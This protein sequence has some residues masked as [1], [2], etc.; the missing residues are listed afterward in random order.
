MAILKGL[1]QMW[2]WFYRDGTIQFSKSFESRVKWGTC[3]FLT[4]NI[5]FWLNCRIQGHSFPCNGT[6]TVI[7]V[8]CLVQTI[9]LLNNWHYLPPW[10]PFMLYTAVAL[11]LVFFLLARSFT[12]TR[13]QRKRRHGRYYGVYEH[14]S[15][16]C[17]SSTRED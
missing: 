1:K 15:T 10:K 16:E 11:M 5:I 7:I 6:N 14:I 13:R 12:L 2:E 9:K 8:I 17:I 4:N 3:R